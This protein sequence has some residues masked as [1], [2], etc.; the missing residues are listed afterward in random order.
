MS[1]KKLVIDRDNSNRRLDNY[2]MSI[3]FDLPKSKIYS[4]IRKG[5]I[6]INSGRAKPSSKILEGDNLRLPPYI[7]IPTKDNVFIPNKLKELIKKSIILLYRSP[8][9]P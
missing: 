6:R 9:L 8:S 7:N 5:E 2:L 3:L 1:V 4:M